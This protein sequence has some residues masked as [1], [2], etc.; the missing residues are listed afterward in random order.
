MCTFSSGQTKLACKQ[1]KQKYLCSKVFWF[2]PPFLRSVQ[3]SLTF[4]AHRKWKLKQRR[5]QRPNSLTKEY[6]KETKCAD[7]NQKMLMESVAELI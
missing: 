5:S 4:P 1:K 2:R 7:S 6:H 3:L